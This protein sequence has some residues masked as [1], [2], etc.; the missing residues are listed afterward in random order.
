MNKP[1]KEHLKGI[2]A[3]QLQNA[4]EAFQREDF[5][6]VVRFSASA[7]KFSAQLTMLQ[8]EHLASS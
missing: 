1:D 3:S 8:S 7:A 6:A 2:L 5:L 4:Q